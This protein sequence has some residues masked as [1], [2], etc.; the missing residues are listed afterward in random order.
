VSEALHG[1]PGHDKGT[2]GVTWQENAEWAAYVVD[3]PV[4][5][6]D[7]PPATRGPHADIESGKTALELHLGR[8]TPRTRGVTG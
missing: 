7:L 8:I 2:A 3:C 6:D 4:C 5:G 1:I